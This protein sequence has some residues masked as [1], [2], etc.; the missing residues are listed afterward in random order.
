[1]NKT[2]TDFKFSEIFQRSANHLFPAGFPSERHYTILAIGAALKIIDD[3]NHRIKQLE[4][5][6]KGL[7]F[8]EDP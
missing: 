4:R 1:M 7:L 6:V 8:R 5:Q 2:E 3:Q